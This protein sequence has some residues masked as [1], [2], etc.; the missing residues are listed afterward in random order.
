VTRLTLVRW[1]RYFRDHFPQTTAW[2]MLVGRL[3]PP[4][5]Q[6]GLVEDL[7][8]RF[9]RARGDPEQGLV[10]CLVALYPRAA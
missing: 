8:T 4:V 5:R 7:L 3:W 9:V 6:D 2:R 1:L 10:A